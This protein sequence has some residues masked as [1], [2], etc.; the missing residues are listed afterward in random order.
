MRAPA[1]AL[2]AFQKD[3]IEDASN[4]LVQIAAQI[5]LVVGTLDAMPIGNPIIAEA[6]NGTASYAR[7]QSERLDKV[8]ALGRGI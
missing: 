3:V 1:P 7:W 5:D 8:P 6:L 2:T 4:A